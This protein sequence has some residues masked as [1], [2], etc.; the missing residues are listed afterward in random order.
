MP[1]RAASG[2]LDPAAME[3]GVWTEEERASLLLRERR[4]RWLDA[5]F[6]ARAHDLNL[7]SDGA[8]RRLQVPGIDLS[9]RIVRIQQHADQASPRHQFPQQLQRFPINALVN[10]LTPVTLP[11]GL[12]SCRN[13]ACFDRIASDDEDDRQLGGRGLYCQRRW[14]PGR[15]YRGDRAQDQIGRQSGQPIVMSFRPAVLDHDVPALDIAGLSETFS[16]IGDERRIV[17][18]LGLMK[19]THN[20]HR[21]LRP[22]RERPRAPLRRAA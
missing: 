15:A 14:K 19:K 9:V 13:Q 4:E 16:E 21:L 8:C 1:W 18:R 3:E 10:W 7:L 20:G 6:A 17:R 5:L 11:A 12:L 2:D 22:R